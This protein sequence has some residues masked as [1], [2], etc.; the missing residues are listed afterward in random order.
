MTFTYFVVVSPPVRFSREKKKK[1]QFP[2]KNSFVF[3]ACFAK[4]FHM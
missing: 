4:V 1:S 2:E 3:L